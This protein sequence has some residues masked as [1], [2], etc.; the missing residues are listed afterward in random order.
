MAGTPR[1]RR[2]VRKEKRHV[3]GYVYGEMVRRQWSDRDLARKMDVAV[4]DLRHLF[5]GGLLTMR[6]ATAIGRAFGTGA[7]TWLTLDAECRRHDQFPDDR[8]AVFPKRE[9]VRRPP[10]S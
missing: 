6:V 9:A 7:A 5:A 1:G 10:R 3:G 2:G 4:S 8:T